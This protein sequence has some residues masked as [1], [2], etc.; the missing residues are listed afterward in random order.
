MFKGALAHVAT[1][2]FGCFMR[3][4]RGAIGCAG[5]VKRVRCSRIR[6]ES[7]MLIRSMKRILLAPVA[8]VLAGFLFTCYIIYRVVVALVD[9]VEYWLTQW[10]W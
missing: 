6:L 7:D 10:G 8:L 1:K 9:E 4:T 3:G 2:S 5:G